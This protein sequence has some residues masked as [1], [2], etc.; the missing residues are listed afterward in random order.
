MATKLE[1]NDASLEFLAQFYSF[2]CST[3]LEDI[4]LAT[5]LSWDGDRAQPIVKNKEVLHSD[6]ITFSN[7]PGV[8]GV[9][10]F[11]SSLKARLNKSIPESVLL[12]QFKSETQREIQIFQSILKDEE[13]LQNH[14]NLPLSPIK[15]STGY[16]FRGKFIDRGVSPASIFDN[17]SLGFEC[18]GISFIWMHALVSDLMREWKI[19]S[20]LVVDKE[21][22]KINLIQVR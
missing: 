5:F 3:P 7:I 9:V 4:E 16:L 17:E 6:L 2:R 15:I 13:Q 10:L 19:P 14:S 20:A 22:K 21:T 12:D 8:G 18:L 11:P 1:K